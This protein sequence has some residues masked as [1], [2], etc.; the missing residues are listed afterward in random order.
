MEHTIEGWD[1]IKNIN[2]WKTK[3]VKY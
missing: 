2:I 3:N 1:K